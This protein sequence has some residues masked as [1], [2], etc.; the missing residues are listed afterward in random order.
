MEIVNR[1]LEV[2]VDPTQADYPGAHPD[3]SRVVGTPLEKAMELKAKGSMYL[4]GIEAAEL[5]LFTSV[6]VCAF[7]CVACVCARAPC[8]CARRVCVFRLSS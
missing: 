6:C 7:V 4:L 1:L 2:G 8:V 5:A 3:R